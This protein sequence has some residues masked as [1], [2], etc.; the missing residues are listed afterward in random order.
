M[1]SDEVTTGRFAVATKGV[2]KRPRETSE[3]SEDSE[4]FHG[5]RDSPS[6]SRQG[7]SR[8][9]S[10]SRPKH[11]RVI[12]DTPKIHR[13]EFEWRLEELWQEFGVEYRFDR[14]S[15]DISAMSFFG[16]PASSSASGSVTASTAVSSRRIMMVQPSSASQEGAANLQV[17]APNAPV[18][19]SQRHANSSTL[20]RQ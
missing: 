15:S 4:D 10:R 1:S 5:C 19:A 3:S 16:G 6:P 17:L 18:R 12:L 13:H 20:G 2:R 11:H 9:S 7:S 14:S 8:R